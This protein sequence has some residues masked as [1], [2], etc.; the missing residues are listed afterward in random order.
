[1]YNIYIGGII[2]IFLI[3]IFLIILYIRVMYNLNLF[4]KIGQIFSNTERKIRTRDHIDEVKKQPIERQKVI[5]TDIS[6]LFIVILT[7]FL[8]A[9]K[10]I[11]FAV[12]LSGSMVPTFDRN[13]LILVQNIDR[14]YDMGDIVIFKTPDR[15]LPITHRIVSISSDGTIRTAGD[16]TGMIDWWGLKKEDIIGKIVLIMGKP[17]VIKEYGKFFIVEDRN[18]RFGPFDYGRFLLFISVIKMY[19]YVIIALS[20]MVYIYLTFKKDKRFEYNFYRFRE[21]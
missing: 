4:E 6:I 11:F 17:I 16:A 3:F 10:S 8:I 7:I 20:I 15:N 18:Q 19:G 1:M 12:V 5:L 2:F 14:N 9:T 13:D 21:R